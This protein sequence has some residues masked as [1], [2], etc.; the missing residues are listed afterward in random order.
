[1]LAFLLV[2]IALGVVIVVILVQGPASTS[3]R[4]Q[5]LRTVAVKSQVTGWGVGDWPGTMI[6]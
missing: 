5:R 4:V 2:M 3:A 1:L 6:R